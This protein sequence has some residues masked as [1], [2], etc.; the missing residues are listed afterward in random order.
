[1]KP[2]ILIISAMLAFAAPSDAAGNSAP[3]YFSSRGYATAAEA[4][5]LADGIIRTG[6]PLGLKF[7]QLTPRKKDGLFS[8]Q[9]R[10]GGEVSALEY[11]ALTAYAEKKEAA[12]AAQVLVS[13]FKSAG[14]QVLA[15]ALVK[16]DGKYLPVVYYACHKQPEAKRFA[17]HSILLKASAPGSH[18]QSVA[19]HLKSMG[20]P[21]LESG[22]TAE[23]YKIAF[24]SKG[25]PSLAA[26]SRDYNSLSDAQAEMNSRRDALASANALILFSGTTSS[27]G[28][29][30]YAI[31]YIE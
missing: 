2:V 19:A 15:T 12:A 11:T 8:L 21:V 22:W 10:T 13:A 17:H 4:Q 23:G 5:V 25:A 20:I 9:G 27:H 30:N 7:D 1:M 28:G 29:F 3:D 6:K 31:Y 18:A 14:V 26:S 24:M 16:E